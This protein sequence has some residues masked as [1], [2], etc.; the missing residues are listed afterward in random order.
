M[1]Q[2][3]NELGTQ[4]TYE[5]EQSGST[6]DLATADDTSTATALA[7][8]DAGLA[9]EDTEEI[10]GQIEATRQQMGETIDAIQERLSVANISEQ[11]SEQVNNAVETAKSA[12]Y[13]ATIGKAADLVR[14]VGEK[15]SRSNIL[16]TAQSNPIPLAMIGI[17]ATWLILRSRSGQTSSPR[18]RRV[19]GVGSSAG[20]SD[21]STGVTGSLAGAANTA[22][23]GVTSRVGSVYH[24]A[25]DAAGQLYS[26]VG[27]L[28]S[29]AREQYSHYMEES[30]LAVGA[31]AL[32]LGAAVGFSLPSTRYEG[33]LMGSTR[34]QLL[35][36]AQDTASE[37]I[38]RTKE[39]VRDAASAS[40]DQS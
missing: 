31:V 9:T 22:Y 3:G 21:K 16:K 10:R 37:L 15:M 25:G 8:R 27:D 33:E 40:T 23:D 4:D 38:E 20:D 39:T 14:D 26:K 1:A 29:N 34:E 5:G 7:D 19:S 28:G 30:P 13:D 17:G 32:A 6:A 2:E 36:K 12:V 11:V 35:S 24:G 18:I